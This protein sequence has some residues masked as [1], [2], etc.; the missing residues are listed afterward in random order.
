MLNVKKLVAVV[1][2][3]LMTVGCASTGNG[4]SGKQQYPELKV[5]SDKPYVWDDSISEALNVARMAQPAGVGNGMRDFADGT[6]ANTGRIG[7]GTRVFDAGLGLLSQGI[8][9]V[10]SMEALNQGVN[11]QLDWKPSIVDFIP[12]KDVPDGERFKFVQNYIGDKLHDAFKKEYG[13]VNW[14]G[15]FTPK[16]VFKNLNTEYVLFDNDACKE[17]LKFEMY[18]KDAEVKYLDAS[19]HREFVEGNQNIGVFCNYGGVISI[20]GKRLING[21]ENYIVVFESS[22]GH[23]FDSVVAKH[24]DGYFIMPEMYFFSAIDRTARVVINREMASV[25]KSGNELLFTKI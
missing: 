11:R 2:A 10:V 20:A 5:L 8:F 1:I 16:R 18:N 4:D 15:P 6:L 19:K 24:Y 25:Y 14:H 12:V 23:F 7:G 21:E 17:S 3:S 13:E 9:G 22:F